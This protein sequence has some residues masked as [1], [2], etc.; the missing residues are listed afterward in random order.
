[1]ATVFKRA[2][3]PFW[4]ATWTAAD[5][6]RKRKCTKTRDKAAAKLIAAEHEKQAALR[7]AGVIDSTQ[8]RFLEQERRSLAEHLAEFHASI[9]ARGRTAQHCRET[10]AMVERI[11]VACDAERIADLTASGVEQAI[12]NLLRIPKSKTPSHVLP[13]PL[14][15]RAK[16]AH[17][18]AIK[19]FTRWLERDRRARLDPLETLAAINEETDRRHVRREL[20][21]AEFAQLIEATA[22]FTR[23][24]HLAPG[25]DRAMFYRLAFGTGF[26]AGELRS[27][28]P[29]SFE[30]KEHREQL[31]TR[32]PQD[33]DGV[34]GLLRGICDGG[35]AISDHLQLLVGG[36]VLEL[37][38]G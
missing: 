15:A 3:S 12:S 33:V 21:A 32:L 20:T 23:P 31:R 5:G 9:Q 10:R 28:T 30:L 4:Y 37:L 8:D 18:R 1:M 35:Q 38:C 34:S 2:R 19:S 25:P 24:E 17:L 29:Q 36:F 26:R 27:L 6:T 13:E 14:S 22:A 11:L 7:R 16:N